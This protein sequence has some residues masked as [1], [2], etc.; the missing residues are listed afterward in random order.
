[1]QTM[2]NLQKNIWC[3]GR[4]MFTIFKDGLNMALP[5][6]KTRSL[7]ESRWNGKK[8]Q[9]ERIVRKVM[10]TIS[11]DK[12]KNRHYWFPWKNTTINR[13]SSRKIH[14]IYWMSL[15]LSLSL[16]LTHTHT[17][18]HTHIYIYIHESRL[19]SSKPHSERRAT[20]EHFGLVGWLVGCFFLF[21]TISTFEGYS[22][23]KPSFEKNSSGTI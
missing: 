23:P 8:F 3:L 10:L 15:S 7:K 16:S 1:M 5:L 21:H 12:K 2:W 13:A 9:L 17:H 18:T 14:F 4:S 11:W 22:M 19:K 6:K 20:D